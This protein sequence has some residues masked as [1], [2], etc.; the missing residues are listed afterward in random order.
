M[1]AYVLPRNAPPYAPRRWLAGF[2]RV[3]LKPGEHRVVKIPFGP[4][5]LT[6][7]DEAGT[8]RPLDGDVDIAVG[9]QQPGRDGRYADTTVGS[10]TTLHLGR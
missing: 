5:A 2:S 4:N 3:S 8:R 10:T 1:Q 7:V 6:Y 9:G